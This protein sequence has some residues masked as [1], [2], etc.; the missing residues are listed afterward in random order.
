MKQKIHPFTTV[1]ALLCAFGLVAAFTWPVAAPILVALAYG[2]ALL[3][4]IKYTSR[5]QFGMLLVSGTVLGLLL[6]QTHSTLPVMT[7][8]M[9]LTAL[10]TILRQAKMQVFTYVKYTWVEPVLIML[11]LSL[12]LFQV[13]QPGATWQ[14]I[15]LPI[16][17]LMYAGMLVVLYV[18]DGVLLKRKASGG[19]RVQLGQKAPDFELP[20]QSGNSVRLSDYIGNHPVLLVFVRG[21]WCPGCH[22]M[23][24]TY[25]RN[26]EHFLE[27][28]IH[29]LGIGPDS[30]DVN[31]DMVERIGVGYELLSD[32]GQRT[33][34]Q[35]G[36]VYDNPMLE[37]GVD[38]TE[39]IPL[40]ASFLVDIEG[41]IRYVSRPD[42]VGEFLDP[43]LIFGVLDALPTVENQLWKAA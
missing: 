19:Y 1:G 21:D 12:Y 28:G 20:N 32:S 6:D 40:P 11:A 13:L 8:V 15:A 39:G 14:S 10:A 4:F 23:L 22:I 43:A 36:V 7:M 27:K 34:Q 41:T 2:L 16:V 38:Y 30:V 25:E 9:V 29:V 37:V 24:R 5:F 3:E 35:Y 18:Q 26:R 31:K 42:R 33:S 17:P